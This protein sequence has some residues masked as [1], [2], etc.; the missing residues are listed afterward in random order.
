MSTATNNDNHTAHD[1][2]A[3][4][5][6]H[7]EVVIPKDLPQPSRGVI[8]GVGIAIV[9]L[10]AT[11]FAIGYIPHHNRNRE[12][13]ADAS[14]RASAI[15]LVDVKNPKLAPATQELALPCDIRAN[16]TT[17]IY[18]R[19]NGYLK[20]LYVDIQDKVEAGQL[21]AEIDAPE[22][23]AELAQRQAALEQSK[24][25]Y[26]K[27]QSDVDLAQ[28]TYDRYEESARMS[29]GSVTAEQ[30]DVRKAA[31]D[32]A[33]SA[34]AQAKANIVAAEADVQQLT[35]TKGFQKV[36]APFAGIITARN[37]DV[38]A[39]LN[40]S[41]TAAGH[42]LF[43][44]AQ[45]DTMRVFVNVPQ[46]YATQIKTGQQ[47]TLSVRNYPGRKFEGKVVRTSGALAADTRTLTFELHFPNPD[48]SLYAGMYGQARLP[49]TAPDKVLVIPSSSLVFNAGGL[50]VA[51]VKDDT[52]RFQKINVGRDLGTEVEIS[53]GVTAED[54]VVTNP[55]EALSEGAKVQLAKKP[56]P[57]KPQSG[58]AIAK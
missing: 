9:V 25:S 37:Y 6:T 3:A 35:V 49:V 42:E 4:H 14:E 58:V 38:G 36:V 57:A 50:Q 24:A 39:L 16:Q 54:S 11:M 18:P 7:D 8:V 44:L 19:A 52:V 1:D 26:T 53:H 15:P 51:T 45:V 46:N 55:S 21:L 43:G 20:K 41:D 17:A 40:P 13:H 48:G 22:I 31:V 27:A 28:K 56:E 32:Q 34:L 10:F 2:R 23:D 30:L 29:K 47:A 33:V 12:I 5:E